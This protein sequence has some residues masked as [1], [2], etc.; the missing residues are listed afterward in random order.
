MALRM[1]ETAKIRYKG[2]WNFD[3]P[4]PQC[5]LDPHSQPTVWCKA[6]RGNL[7]FFYPLLPLPLYASWYEKYLQCIVYEIILPRVCCHLLPTSGRMGVIFPNVKGVP[8][9]AWSSTADPP[10]QL[11]N[12]HAQ[13]AGAAKY[14]GTFLC[15]QP[16]HTCATASFAVYRYTSNEICSISTSLLLRCHKITCLYFTIWW[17][18][19]L[20]CNLWDLCTKRTK[21]MNRGKS[22]MTQSGC[23]TQRN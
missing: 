13:Y 21:K 9:M 14:D 11:N 15:I 1:A 3:I 2:I 16:G 10:L 19:L 22:R 23:Y 4:R 20:S 5:P 17:M 7:S 12:G 6:I 8:H 18:N